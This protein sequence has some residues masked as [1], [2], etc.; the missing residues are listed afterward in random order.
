M[1]TGNPKEHDT[2]EELQRH[3]EYLEHVDQTKLEDF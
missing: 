2:T 1:L 3:Y